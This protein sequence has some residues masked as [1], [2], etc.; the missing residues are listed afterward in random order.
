MGCQEVGEGSSAK[1]GKFLTVIH[2]HV[3]QFIYYYEL[4]MFCNIHFYNSLRCDLGTFSTDNL[5]CEGSLITERFIHY[6]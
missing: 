1:S 3:I 4:K 2:V 5:F 6:V